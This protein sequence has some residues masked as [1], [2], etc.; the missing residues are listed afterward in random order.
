VAIKLGIE[1]ER[2]IVMKDLL[3]YGR[4]DL[5]S[6]IKKA[7]S[8]EKMDLLLYVLTATNIGGLVA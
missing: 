2:A 3:L 6:G 5:N 4:V 7:N 8:I 1:R